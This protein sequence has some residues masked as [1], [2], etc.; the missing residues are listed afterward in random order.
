MKRLKRMVSCL[1]VTCM[2]LTMLPVTAAAAPT[3]FL[4]KDGRWASHP[5]GYSDKAGTQ[6]T[7]IGVSGCG[8]LAYVNAVYAL[9]GKFIEPTTLGDYSLRNGHRVNGVGTA[10]SLYKSFADNRGSNY[11]IQYIGYETSYSKLRSHLQSGRVAIVSIPGHIMACVDYNSANG[12]FLILDSYPSNNRGTPNGYAWK[13][14]TQM[15]NMGFRSEFYI[16][17]STIAP[18]P[19]TPDPGPAP[20]PTN[21]DAFGHVDEI[22]MDGRTIHVRGWAVDPDDF[23]KQVDI[24][25]Y[26]GNVCVGSGR[27]NT[28]RPDVNNQNPGYG[29]WHGFEFGLAVPANLNGNQP[30]RIHVIDLSGAPNNVIGEGTVNIKGDTTGPVM[31]DAAV[32]DV[33]PTG[34]TVSVR[35]TDESG[36]KKVQFPTWTHANE[37]D[38]IQPDWANNAAAAGVKSGDTYTYRVRISDHKNEHGWYNTHIYAWDNHG[39][40]SVHRLTAGVPTPDYNELN[41]K[42]GS[43]F[44]ACIENANSGTV[45]TFTDKGFGNGDYEVEFAPY[46]GSDRQIW[47]FIRTGEGSYFIRP[48]AD[49]GYGLNVVGGK[50]ADGTNVIVHAATDN[51]AQRWFICRHDGAWYFRP[52]CAPDSYLDLSGGV[53][54]DH[55][56]AQIYTFNTGTGEKMNIFDPKN[57]YTP[58]VEGT[59]GGHTYQV[60]DASLNAEDAQKYCEKLGGH[61]VTITSAEEQTFVES[62]LKK[63]GSRNQYWIGGK[64]VKDTFTWITGE[65]VSYTHWDWNEPNRSTAGSA[66]EDYVHLYN[67]PNPRVDKSARFGWNDTF[68]NSCYPGEQDFFGLQRVGFI[69]EI[70]GKKPCDTCSWKDGPV[71]SYPTCTASGSMKMVCTVCGAEKTVSI[72]ALGHME[73]VISAVEPT[74]TETGLSKG[75]KCA[76]CQK[77]L[78]EQQVLPAK[79]HSWDEGTVTKEPTET[80]EGERTYTCTACG[81][82]KT[83]AIPPVVHEHSYTAA[84]TAPTCT[85]EGY[86]TYTCKC[87]ESY[88]DNILPATGH[89]YDGDRD[90]TCNACGEKREISDAD[91][92]VIAVNN[93][94]GRAGSGVKMQVVIRE[95]KGFAG[96][97]LAVDY[98]RDAMTLIDVTKGELLKESES[99]AFTKNIDSGEVNWTDSANLPGDGELFVLTFAVK[100]NAAEGKYPVSMALKGGAASNFVDEALTNLPVVFESGTV[101]VTEVEPGDLTGD[102]DVT[103][104]DAVLLAK[105]LVG[106]ETLSDKQQKAADVTY[107]NAVTAVDAVKLAKFLVGLIDDLEPGLSVEIRPGIGDVV[108]G[109]G[110]VGGGGIITMPAVIKAENLSAAAG[111]IVRVPVSIAVNEGFAGFT[112]AV[113]YDRAALKLTDISKGELLKT[114]ESGAFTKNVEKGEVNWTD[115]ADLTEDG[116]LFVLTFEVQADSGDHAVEIA[117]KGG[118]EKNFVNAALQSVNTMFEK[119]TVSV[120]VHEHAWDEGVVTTEPTC[121]A[122]GE[123]TYTCACGETRTETLEAKGHREEIIPHA[124]PTC[125]E[126]GLTEGKKCSVCG[127][128]LVE[129]TVVPAKGHTE[130]GIPAVEP[131][132]TETG[133]SAGAK[134]G[135]CGA[136]LAEREII[137]AR[138]HMEADISAVEPTC[139]ETGLSAGVKCGVCD[140]MLVEQEIIPAKG[141]TETVMPGEEPTCTES[142]LSAGVKCGV[143][144]EILTAQEVIGA[145]GHSFEEGVCAVCGAADPDYVE[146]EP[147]V[148]E[149]EP[150][151]VEPEPPVVEP[152][153]PVVEPEEKPTVSGSV[154]GAPAGATVEI[155]GAKVEVK[156]DGSFSIEAAEGEFDVV[157]KTPGALTYTV[158]GVTAEDGSITLPEIAP[159]K[160]DTNGDD[161]INIMDMGAFRANFGKVGG[162]IAN[163]FTDVNGDGMVNIMDMGTF[164]ANFGKTAAKDCTVE[165]GA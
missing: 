103:S 4:Q 29:E 27:A 68:V 82:K 118:E 20:G 97:T 94:S 19:P 123:K 145:N 151:V 86:T 137:P 11:G 155:S 126:T 129:Q 159:V 74:C 37:Q 83:E 60:I 63:G 75:V 156:E 57:N 125:T 138:G 163:E 56:N 96:F 110:G 87:G 36:V 107:D 154:S 131:T 52:S 78:T 79:G 13:T 39:N 130:V 139:T 108:G 55:V 34:Y 33:G 85:E 41:K 95:G 100:E 17:G 72:P 64:F 84:V 16:I 92:A 62:L 90:D 105:A 148:V 53:K 30:V 149:P 61:L 162:S 3:V 112:M 31:K 133:L 89:T 25:V 12:T 124:E 127:E 98:D 23:G 2:L 22:R 28:C 66:K 38:D 76:N 152:E 40:Q 164:R 69:C 81:E 65:K 102:G 58:V 141:H 10:F 26:V 142:G 143:C 44:Y 135:I 80:A 114:S 120:T 115:S 8:I 35:V 48:K 46:T 32:Y 67:A 121:T 161:M 43:D 59:F 45:L 91:T 93:A 113:D 51:S 21:K 160:G 146:P 136:V 14:E 70:D 54:D 42:F 106:L 6:A 134:C 1:L 73:A 7:N 122:P 49:E 47:H 99:G 5:Y 71:I 101:E 111:E 144:G 88:K 116:E 50:S 104:V 165:Y 153:P 119:G 24:H 109:I 150:P 77:V 158:K 157:I 15:K 117:L 140:A 9:N 18:V 132:C 147:P 128:M